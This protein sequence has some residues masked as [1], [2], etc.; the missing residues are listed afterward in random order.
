[1]AKLS[2]ILRITFYKKP[3]TN[4]RKFYNVHKQTNKCG[5][6]HLFSI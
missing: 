6:V 3:L 2:D 5:T 1:M 4:N